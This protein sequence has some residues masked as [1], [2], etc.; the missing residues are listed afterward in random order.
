MA[1]PNLLAVVMA[2]A[3][4][5]RSSEAMVSFCE[6]VMSWKLNRYVKEGSGGDVL[7]TNAPWPLRV[8]DAGNQSP[9]RD[10]S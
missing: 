4:S 8:L 5:G 2:M 6:Q 3:G 9:N 10:N 1:R 7:L